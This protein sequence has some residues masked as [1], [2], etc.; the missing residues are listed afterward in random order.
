MIN[1]PFLLVESDIVFEP[2]MLKDMLF[3]D[4]IAIASQRP[5]MNGTTVSISHN[6]EIDAF[7]LSDHGTDF[8]N[9]DRATHRNRND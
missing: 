1:E 4:R 5:W 9:A 2:S 8:F 6:Q 7:W 3:P